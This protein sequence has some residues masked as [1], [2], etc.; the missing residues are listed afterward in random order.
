MLTAT[1]VPIVPSGEANPVRNSDLK[2][3]QAGQFGIARV[4]QGNA[5]NPGRSRQAGQ[6]IVG[7]DN[8]TN[9]ITHKATTPKASEIIV[10]DDLI[11]TDLISFA[12]VM[13]LA[14]VVFVAS[15]FSYR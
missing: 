6:I 15:L 3:G 4:G 11:S 5:E 8:P 9:K 14:V 10:S 12:M 1:R 13:L 7:N 2:V